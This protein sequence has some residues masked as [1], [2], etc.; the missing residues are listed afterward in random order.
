MYEMQLLSKLFYNCFLNVFISGFAAKQCVINCDIG[1]LDCIA[2]M[3]ETQKTGVNGFK[4]HLIRIFFFDPPGQST[5]ISSTF[6]CR[7]VGIY[8]YLDHTVFLLIFSVRPDI[9][10][11]S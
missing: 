9:P 11:F 6:P 2:L 3:T 8:S 1:W 10:P 7:P 4:L 5:E